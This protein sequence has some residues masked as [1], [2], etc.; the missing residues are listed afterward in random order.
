MT[1]TNLRADTRFLVFGDSANT[2]YG[3][4]DLDRNLNKAYA[5]I[6]AIAISVNDDFQVNGNIIT[7]D[8][9][10]GRSDYDLPSN[11][12]K[13]NEVRIKP[14]LSATDYLKA[15]QRDPK[16]VLVDM[17]VYKPAN[18]EFDLIDI[19]GTFKIIFYYASA[20]E[21]VTD[22]IEFYIQ[23]EITQLVGTSDSPKL[24]VFAQDYLSNRAAHIYCLAK[25][26][27]NKATVLKNELIE[28]ENKIKEY[29]SSR[30]TV[31]PVVITSEEV[32][33]F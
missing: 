33:L 23:E 25:E 28:L 7:T 10:A 14:T 3:D 27:F 21:T 31:R 30:S 1:L 2:Q 13:I 18:P 17:E 16:E 22:G 19:K 24:P 4:T 8:L 9:I 5:E 29:Y 11:L 6:I 26:K 12:F 15:T 20:F 32:N